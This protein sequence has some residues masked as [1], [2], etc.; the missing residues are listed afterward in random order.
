MEQ[1]LTDEEIAEI[2]LFMR[3]IDFLKKNPEI[4]REHQVLKRNYEELSAKINELIASLSDEQLNEVLEAHNIQ[5]QELNER[6][7]GKQVR[8]RRKSRPK[9]E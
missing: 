4:L 3:V 6:E 7:I 5:L 2:C 8:K 1:E 9:P